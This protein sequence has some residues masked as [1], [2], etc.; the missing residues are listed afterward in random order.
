MIDRDSFAVAY[1]QHFSRTWRFLQAYGVPA[2]LAEDVAQDAWAKGWERRHQ[3][4]RDEKIASW[5]NTIA[6]NFVFEPGCKP[7]PRK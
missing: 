2:D 7:P 4:H 5:I 3:L 6:L 1:P